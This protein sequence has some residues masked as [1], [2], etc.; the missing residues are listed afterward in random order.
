MEETHQATIL[1][2]HQV[3]YFRCPSCEFWRT[4]EPWW[5]D[6]A[7]SHA[8]AAA[9]TGIMTRNL[10]VAD[11]LTWLMPRLSPS[12]PYVDW[13]GGHGVLVRLMRDRGFDFYWHDAHA[14]N[15]YAHGFEWMPLAGTKEAS[16]VTAIEVFEHVA[17]PVEFVREVFESTGAQWLVFT[18]EVHDA[19]TDPSWQYFAPFSGQH[20]SFFSRKTLSVLAGRLG[21]QLSVHGR[22]W[23]ISRSQVRLGFL[24]RVSYFFWRAERRL[25]RGGRRSLVRQDFETITGR[26]F[27]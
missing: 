15:D 13:G 25:R 20:I 27:S 16:L 2:R 26:P 5:L 3:R 11:A 12:G 19:S 10:S 8:I 23:I 7:Y 22:L 24:D 1:D 17:D 6:E 18:T 21:M 14:S 9:D 4:E